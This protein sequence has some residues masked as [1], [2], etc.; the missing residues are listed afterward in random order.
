MFPTPP[1]PTPH[2]TMTDMASTVDTLVI[3]G[4]VSGLSTAYHL[5]RAGQS[6]QILEAAERLGGAIGTR[7]IDGWQFETGPNTLMR[8]PDLNVLLSELDL[9]IEAV[10]ANEMAK[11]RF[12]VKNGHP[13]ALP[14]G[15]LE[16]LTSPL[17][18]L[19]D[20]LHL[21]REPWIKPATSEETIAQFVQRRLG[22]GFLDWAIDPFVSGVYAGDPQRLSVRAATPK[23]YALEQ[24]YGSLIRGGLAKMKAARQPQADG[25]SPEKKG[26]I[27]FPAGMG[28]LISRLAD[29]IHQSGRG[30]IRI[31]TPVTA[32][33]RTADGIWLAEST[34]GTVIKAK[35][36][37]LAIP[38]GAAARLLSPLNPDLADLLAAI[39][40]PP[41]TSVVLGFDR[42]QVAHP[43]NGFGM[44]IPGREQ[45]RTLGV[46]FSSTLFPNRAPE[47]K[48]LLTAFIG[49][50]RHP[51]AAEGDDDALVK[52]VVADLSPL[53][54]IR[55]AP[56]FEQVQRWP[57]AIPQYELGHLERLQAIEAESRTLPGLYLAG[58]WRTGIAVGDCLQGGAKL[59]RTMASQ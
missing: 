14:G 17:F 11:K 48:V 57:Q 31:A 9:E 42:Q 59:A 52:R 36:V 6:V 43:L 47:G 35:S 10:T 3:G 49:G 51:E 33:T 4:G 55:G 5:T 29:R 13:V 34:E 24:E 1:V 8:S 44:L 58:N 41:V 2:P 40:Y 39:E 19:G 50:R 20:L 28:V 18:G 21:A 27:S 46:L 15:P 30:Q 26:L 38:A 16:L 23:I 56:T 25:A 12:V 37:V 54:G 7:Q 32:L 22:Q 45:R 53:L